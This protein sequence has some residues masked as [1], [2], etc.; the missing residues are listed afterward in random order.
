MKKI[1]SLAVIICLTALVI[2]SSCSQKH[3]IEEFKARM[4]N[5]ESYQMTVTMS[6]IPVFGSITMAY[7][8]D[9]NIQHSSAVELM[10]Q[11]EYYLEALEDSAY[12]YT[13]NSYGRWTKTQ[14]TLAESSSDF[15]SE[16]TINELFDTNNYEKVKDEDNTY[17][18]KKDVVFDGYDE[19]VIFVGENACT[20]EMNVITED[21]FACA[22]KIVISKIGE[23]ELVLPQLG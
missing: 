3:P 17:K 6:D 8:I 12:M 14:V 13:K 7:E 21:G 16:E 10:G 20:I 15:T 5:A 1:T 19:V 11:E 22:T 4:E 9:G 2:F 23:V 18:Q